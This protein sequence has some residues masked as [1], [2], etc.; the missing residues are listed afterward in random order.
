L[1]NPEVIALEAAI[2]K[3]RCSAFGYGTP[4][5]L[6]YNQAATLDPGSLRTPVLRPAGGSE[7]RDMQI[8]EARQYF[9]EGR[10]RSIDL[11]RALEGP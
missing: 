4:A 6:R 5:Y 7:R 3:A 11:L 8:E 9:S 1:G 10:E 2:D